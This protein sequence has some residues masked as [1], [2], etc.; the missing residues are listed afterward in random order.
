MSSAAAIPAPS[1]AGAPKKSKKKLVILL[2]IPLVLIAIL[3]GLWFG[4]I[5][6]PLLGMGVDKAAKHEKPG[7]ISKEAAATAKAPVFLDLPDLI[8][9]LNVG[10]RR[11][12]FIKLKAKLELSKP[13][14]VAVVTAAMP[15]LQDMFTTYL[16]EMRPEELR[17]SAGTYRLREEMI[18]RAN[19]AAAPARIVDVLFSEMLIQ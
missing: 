6:P 12:A 3:A 4:G 13:E 8:A 17:G 9:N 16:R 14:D 18:S 11:S 15:R 10:Q 5:L 7:E 1:E 19:I 2:A